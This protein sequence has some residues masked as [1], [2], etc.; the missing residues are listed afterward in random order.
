[1]KREWLIKL[2]KDSGKTFKQIAE[3]LNITQQFYCF[4]E[5]GTRRPSPE[6]AQKIA[7]LFGFEWTKFFEKNVEEESE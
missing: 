3:E 1:M 7:D 6:L 4:I 5:N 2:R